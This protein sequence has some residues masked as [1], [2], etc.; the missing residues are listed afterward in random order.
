MYRVSCM[1]K[2]GASTKTYFDRT[3]QHDTPK[4]LQYVLKPFV[5]EHSTGNTG[6]MRSGQILSEQFS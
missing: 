6:T 5:M 4:W 1:V 2:T 3:L